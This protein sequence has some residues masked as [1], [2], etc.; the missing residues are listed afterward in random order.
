MTSHVPTAPVGQGLRAYRLLEQLLGTRPGADWKQRQPPWSAL[1]GVSDQTCRGEGAPVCRAHPA[2]CTSTTGP[3]YSPP[4]CGPGPR[5]C[6]PSQR[7]SQ[8]QSDMFH[9]PERQLPEAALSPANFHNSEAL[10]A[11]NAATM[12]SESRSLLGSGRTESM[13]KIVAKQVLHSLH[14][15]QMSTETK[16]YTRHLAPHLDRGEEPHQNPSSN[17][18][19]PRRDR[20]QGNCSAGSL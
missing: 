20:E 15:P 4:S 19:G 1:P 10:A 5:Q 9:R 18:H 17:S 12:T 3:P 14:H 11:T 2:G 16:V 13:D 6:S 7:A 8:I